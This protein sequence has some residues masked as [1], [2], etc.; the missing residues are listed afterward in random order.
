VLQTPS[1]TTTSTGAQSGIQFANVAPAYRDSLRRN[2]FTMLPEGFSLDADKAIVDYFRDG[3]Y[4]YYRSAYYY[5][6]INKSG[7][8]YYEI[9]W[10]VLYDFSFD[11]P[12]L[13]WLVPLGG[14]QIAPIGVLTSDA[15]NALTLQ[16]LRSG[17]Y[18]FSTDYLDLSDSALILSDISGNPTPGYAFAIKTS[19]GR[20]VKVRIFY[21]NTYSG[22]PYETNDLWLQIYVYK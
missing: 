2:T 21:I 4:D 10:D 9:P 13:R 3:Y 17:S 18:T 14:A 6:F 5:D 15:F 19:L 1:K 7:D 8:D 20:Y 16:D 11:D 12:T 22:D